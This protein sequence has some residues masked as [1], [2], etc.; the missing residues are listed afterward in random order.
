MVPKIL[1]TEQKMRIKEVCPDLLGK[2]VAKPYCG[3]E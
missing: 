3:G 1:S 2:N